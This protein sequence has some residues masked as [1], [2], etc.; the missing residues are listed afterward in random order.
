MVIPD[1]LVE[2]QQLT[3]LCLV[4]YIRIKA[5][6]G[7]LNKALR[8]RTNQLGFT[9]QAIS[10]YCFILQKYGYLDVIH[11]RGPGQSNQYTLLK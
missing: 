4:F 9:R 7:G 6:A 3:P 2:N 10:K 8:I 11:S 5:L 1:E